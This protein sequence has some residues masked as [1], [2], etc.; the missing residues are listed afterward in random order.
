MDYCPIWKHT[1]GLIGCPIIFRFFTLLHAELIREVSGIGASRLVSIVSGIY[2][3]TIRWVTLTCPNT[4]DSI[5][6]PFSHVA[7]LYSY[8][9]N[10]GRRSALFCSCNASTAVPLSTFHFIVHL[11]YVLAGSTDNTSDIEHHA[12]D[13][14]VVSIG[15]VDGPGAQIPDLVTRLANYLPCFAWTIIRLSLPVCSCRG[16][17][18]PDVRR[19]IAD[20]LLGLCARRGFDELDHF[21]N[22]TVSPSRLRFRKPA[23]TQTLGEPRRNLLIYRQH[24]PSVSMRLP[25]SMLSRTPVPLPTSRLGSG[26]TGLSPDPSVAGSCQPNLRPGHL[27]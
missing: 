15:I 21:V 25:R 19:Q 10:Y 26:R 18:S 14:I 3:C 16:F 1:P 20:T 12:G 8:T 22:P 13:G 23:Q 11:D 24:G 7:I 17:Q 5:A 9:L 27:H 2:I 4:N 6:A